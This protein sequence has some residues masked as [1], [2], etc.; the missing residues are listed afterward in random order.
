MSEPCRSIS[1]Q[2]WVIHSATALGD[3]GRLLDPDRGGRPE[4]LDLRR[5][6]QDRHAVRRQREQAVDGVADADPLVAEDVGYELE[7]LLNLELEVV[8]GERQLRRRQR[9]RRD[10]RD[11]VR[12][13][14]D[15]PMGVRA[16]LEVAAV[17]ALVHVGV[18]VAHDRERDLADG[19]G[20]L[21]DRPDADHLVHGRA[22]RDG[23]ARHPRDARA[24]HAAGDDD[25]VGLDVALVRWTLLMW[26]SRRRGP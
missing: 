9:G 5:L 3:P 18:H 25:D 15:R 16:D 22:E 1:D 2:P 26:P 6:A 13:H 24:P 11:V 4:A 20:E 7:R 8:L 12:L 23:R 17:L 21:R 14:K 10:R 19:V